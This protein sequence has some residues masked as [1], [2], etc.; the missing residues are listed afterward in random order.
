MLA[1]CCHVPSLPSQLPRQ[2]TW[3]PSEYVHLMP[4]E[5]AGWLMKHSD[6]E[7]GCW[8]MV[9]SRNVTLAAALVMR[10]PVEVNVVLGLSHLN[11]GAMEQVKDMVPTLVS[12]L[13][14]H[15][16]LHQV[17]WGGHPAHESVVRWVPRKR[18]KSIT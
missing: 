8:V 4:V 3:G 11:V 9:L 5:V 13:K 7:A 18:D 2:I 6:I 1:L 17:R 16:R 15:S 10:A 12:S 14:L